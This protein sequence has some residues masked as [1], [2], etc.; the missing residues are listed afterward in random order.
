MP[1]FACKGNFGSCSEGQAPLCNKKKKVFY[2]E[3]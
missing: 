2:V 1:K 3:C